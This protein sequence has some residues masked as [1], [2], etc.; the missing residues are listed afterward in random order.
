M[1]YGSRLWLY[2]GQLPAM[3]LGSLSLRRV[4]L[5]FLLRRLVLL[6]SAFLRIPGIFCRPGKAPARR[7]SP[8]PHLSSG[9]GCLRSQWRQD[10]YGAH[11]SARSKRK[12]AAE[13]GAWRF[14]WGG[15][16]R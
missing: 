5:R 1:D 2:L 10:W 4:A 7:S 13:F 8:A 14:L 15:N 3:G 6:P 9:D 16:E 12:D 11:A